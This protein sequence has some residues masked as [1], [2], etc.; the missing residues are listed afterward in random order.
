MKTSLTFDL[1]VCSVSAVEKACYRFSD[2][3]VVDIKAKPKELLVAVE[4]M[5]S[6]ISP[7][8]FDLAVRQLKAEVLDQNLREKIKLETAGVRNLILAHA[9]SRTGLVEQAPT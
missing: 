4:S 7:I 5:R 1:G 2:R 8:A 3:L 9:F 6:D